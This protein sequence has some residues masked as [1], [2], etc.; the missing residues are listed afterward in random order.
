MRAYAKEIL[1]LLYLLLGFEAVGDRVAS[2]GLSLELALYAGVFAL[3]AACAFAAAWVSNFLLRGFYALL[4]FGSALFLH[5]TESATDEHL[6]YDAFVNLFNSRGFAGDALRQYGVAIVTAALTS[7]P[8]LVGIA[9]KPRGNPPLPR[10]AAVAPLA[11]IALLSAILFARGGDGARGL[12]GPFAPIAYAS[13]LAYESGTGLGQ[14]RQEVSL[15][16]T[17]PSRRDIVLIVDESVLGSYLDINHRTGVRSGLLEPRRGVVVHNFGFAASI[18]NCSVGSNVTLRYGGTRDDYHRIN[19]TM[20]SIWAYARRAGLRTVYIDAQGTGGMR[21]N[22]M[23]DAEHALI[24]LF[25]QFDR[26]RVRDRDMAAA[27]R[28]R[29]LLNDDRADFILVNKVGAHFPV[30][31]KY[32]ESHMHYRPALPRGMF[33]NITDT[34]SRDGFGGGAEDWRRYRNAYRNTLTWNVGAF[35]ERLLTGADL[36]RATLIYTS[37]H[38]Q[39]LHERGEPGVTTHCSSEPVDEEGLVPLA[40]IEGAGAPSLDWRRHLAANRHHSSHYNIFPT[41]LELMGYDPAAVRAVYGRSLAEE[42]RDSFT[43]NSRFNARLGKQPVWRHIDIRALQSTVEQDAPDSV[44]HAAA[45][46]RPAGQ[47]S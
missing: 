43:F 46:A 25:I 38:G 27:D 37:D 47:G 26:V 31:D 8:L 2:L 29:R 14:P 5:S 10:I 44:G 34:G 13:L 33:E 45:A 21:H 36:R 17:R 35:F 18:T 7:L 1:L 32:P 39:D 24:D 16:L 20:P 12:P 30:H 15:P 9:L 3:L 19:A 4:F 23:D 28:L 11:G 6:T 41:L 42:T 40:I 22:L